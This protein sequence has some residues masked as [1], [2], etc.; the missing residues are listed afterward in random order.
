MDPI[1]IAICIGGLFFVLKCLGLRYFRNVLGYELNEKVPTPH[2]VFVDSILISGISLA[3]L[4][5]LQ[6]TPTLS[7]PNSTIT[8]SAFVGDAPF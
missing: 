1:F 2:S 5:L 4:W 6:A 7:L 8:P 3:L